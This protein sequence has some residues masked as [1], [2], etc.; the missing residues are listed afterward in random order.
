MTAEL[1]I[2]DAH[3]PADLAAWA[4]VK[5]AVEPEEPSTVAELEHELASEPDLLFPLVRRSGEPVACGVARRSRG[6]EGAAYVLARVIPPARRQ[7]IGAALFDA[8]IERARAF[9]ARELVSRVWEDD[10]AAV[11]FA[12][13]RGFVTQQRECEVRLDLRAIARGGTSKCTPAGVTVV[14]LLD[15]PDLVEAAYV[16]EAETTADVPFAYPLPTPTFEQ[17]R[18]ENLEGPG[19][20][21][22]GCMV[23]I[24]DGNAVGW[25]ALSARGCEEGVAVHLHTGVCRPWRG[26]GVARALKQAQIAWAFD[27][28]LEQLATWNDETNAPMRGLNAQLGYV[29]R[30]AS[31][32]LRGPMPG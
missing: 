3:T 30:P 19:V 25:A 17:W 5:T 18:A 23:A 16:V 13:A 2:S 1:H 12:A 31:L 4:D 29:P 14:S 10:A 8:L 26:R 24:A 6:V 11:R 9:G 22:G 20:L 27:H 32:F 7:G 15:R 28:G 21:P